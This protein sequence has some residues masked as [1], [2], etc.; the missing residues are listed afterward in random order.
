MM[1]LPPWLVHEVEYVL[2]AGAAAFGTGAAAGVRGPALTPEQLVQL[3]RV[4]TADEQARVD[5][6]QSG[7]ANAMQAT[8]EA[9]PFINPLTGQKT[10]LRPAEYTTLPVDDHWFFDWRRFIG[11]AA[12]G[13]AGAAL[14]ALWKSHRVVGGTLGFLAGAGAGLAI[15]TARSGKPPWR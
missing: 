4:L 7:Q 6:W 3:D 8:E 14:G 12:F 13:V 5:A 9:K 15:E 10:V 11:P 2:G 1:S